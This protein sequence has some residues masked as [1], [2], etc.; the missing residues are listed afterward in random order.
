M[1]VIVNV[2]KGSV[3]REV[4]AINHKHL[5]GIKHIFTTAHP[6]LNLIQHTTI[7]TNFAVGAFIREVQAP[8]LISLRVPHPP[9]SRA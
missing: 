3:R 6:S 4:S 2:L 1:S 9:P 8:C 5:A 7:A